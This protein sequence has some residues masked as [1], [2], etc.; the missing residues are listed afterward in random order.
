VCRSRDD[1]LS[2]KIVVVLR[3]TWGKMFC[4]LSCFVV[5]K[6]EVF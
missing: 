6:G 2:E 1:W 3:G 5:L 4:V